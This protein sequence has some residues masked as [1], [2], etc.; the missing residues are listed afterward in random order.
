MN[1]CI[2]EYHTDIRRRPITV[3][4]YQVHLTVRRRYAD[5]ASPNAKAR[6]RGNKM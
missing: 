3:N 6:V 2:Y 5:R 4:A 1:R